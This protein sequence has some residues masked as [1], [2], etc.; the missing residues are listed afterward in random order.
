MKLLYELYFA[1]RRHKL[2]HFERFYIIT[3][4]IVGS[5]FY[6]WSIDGF[7]IASLFSECEDYVTFAFT[8]EVLMGRE[9]VV[10]P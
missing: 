9:E 7:G 4:D 1:M 5:K 8:W 10:C 3:Y 6:I 2:L